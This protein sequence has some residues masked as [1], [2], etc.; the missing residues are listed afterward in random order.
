[1][2]TICKKTKTNTLMHTEVFSAS[3]VCLPCENTDSPATATV[4]NIAEFL[5]KEA[6]PTP[7]QVDM[8]HETSALTPRG[9]YLHWHHRLG[10]LSFKKMTLVIILCILP[11]KLLKVRPPVCAACKYGAMTKRPTRVKGDKNKGQLHQ[12]TKAGECVSVDQM[13]SEPQVSSE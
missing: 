8:D 13:E 2:Q 9:G 11:H 6:I 1:M 3:Y 4:K 5:D 7:T 10:H 12:A